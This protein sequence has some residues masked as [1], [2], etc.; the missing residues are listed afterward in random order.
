MYP[1]N[2]DF[3]NSTAAARVNGYI[4]GHGTPEEIKAT[5][6]NLGISTEGQQQLLAISNKWK[7]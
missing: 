5:L 3:I 7:N 1:R 6:E 2:I 4:G